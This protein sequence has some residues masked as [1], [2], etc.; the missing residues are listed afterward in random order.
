MR[1]ILNEK[2]NEKCSSK[3]WFG[4]GGYKKM[5]AGRGLEIFQ[6]RRGLARKGGKKIERVCESM[7]Y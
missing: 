7:Y 1:R 6:K 3:I 4:E 5:F 2:L